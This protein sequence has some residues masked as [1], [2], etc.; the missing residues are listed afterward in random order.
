MSLQTSLLI[1]IDLLDNSD[2]EKEA[3]KDLL[4][5]CVLVGKYLASKE[6]RSTFYIRK[7]IELEMK[8]LDLEGPEAF[9]MMYR[10]SIVHS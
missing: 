9:Q 2:E 10:R 3:T 6:K 7:R 5:A 4:L 1:E 8:E